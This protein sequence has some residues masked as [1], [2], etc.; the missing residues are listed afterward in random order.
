M[1]QSRHHRL[2]A[3]LSA[4]ESTHRV[5]AVEIPVELTAPYYQKYAHMLAARWGMKISTR[6]M[7]VGRG[8][9]CMFL[10]RR[11]RKSA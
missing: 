10:A 4:L 11:A 5:Q 1:I 8:R 2:H 9:S 3:A 6:A 7:P